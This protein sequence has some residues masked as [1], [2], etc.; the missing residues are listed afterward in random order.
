ME[1]LESAMDVATEIEAAFPATPLGP[2]QAFA[3][4]GLTYLDSEGFRTSSQ[5]RTWR[6][7]PPDFLEYHHDALP[8]L[9]PAAFREYLPAYIAAVVLHLQQLDALPVSLAS[10]LTR[11]HADT[12]LE[13]RFDRRLELLNARQQRAVAMAF[14]FLEHSLGSSLEKKRVTEALDSYWRTVTERSDENG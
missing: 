11:K 10:I 13:A 12:A 2:G 7:L 3:E 1:Q 5:G 8:F 14:L 9:G 4:W 6:E